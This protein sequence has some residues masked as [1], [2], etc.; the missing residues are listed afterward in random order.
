MNKLWTLTALELRSLYGINK[1]LHTKD[2]RAKSRYRMLAVAWVILLAMAFFYVGALVYG[3]CL[4]GLREIVPAYLV[5]IA[6]LLIFA[7]GIF[8]AATAVFGKTGF[9]LLSSMPVSSGAIVLSR[10][11]ALYAEDLILALVVMVPGIGVFAFLQRPDPLFYLTALVGTVFLPAIPLVISVVLDTLI[12]AISAGMKHKSLIQTLLMILLVVGI[13]AGSFQIGPAAESLTPEMLSQMAQTIAGLIGKVYP[14]ALWLGSA[15]VGAASGNL[16]LFLLASLGLMALV[17]VLI[18]RFHHRIMG[19]LLSFSTGQNY[20]I[21][22]ME[23]RSLAKALYFRELRRYFSSSIYVTNTIIGPIMGCLL[24]G[25]L[26]FG[27][28]DALEG[29]LPLDIQPLLPLCFGAVFCMMTTTSTSISMEGRHFWVV[30]SMPIPTKALLDS[31]IA[32]NLSLMA[33]FYVLSEVF[34]IIAA[35]PNPLELLWLVLIPL[36]II[37]FAVVF[38]I[39]VNLKLHSFDWEKEEQ[40]VKQ[41]AS[42]ALGGFAGLLVSALLGGLLFLVP[43]TLDSL[44]KVL[45]CSVLLLATALLYRKN[46][47]VHLENL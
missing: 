33:P 31:K 42:A 38:G 35:K 4:L 23:R 28:M 6:S 37:L 20:Q 9:D 19:A 36:L 8:R 15:M 21:G 14:P 41:S 29:A 46:N 10:I 26:C 39:T 47:T 7:F 16:L 24:T 22:A 44:V 13:L 2:P 30:K 43:E 32:L 45:M 18:S 40:V 25:F 17:T 11:L 5:M 3:L 12:L 34:L 27:G 1:I